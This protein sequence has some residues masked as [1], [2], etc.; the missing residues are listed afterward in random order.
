MLLAGW[1]VINKKTRNTFYR[2]RSLSNTTFS[3]LITWR[4]SSLKS[5]AVYKISW[6]LDDFS[7]RYGD[8]SIFKMAAVH[9]SLNCFTTIRDHPWSL[10]CWPQLPVKFQSDTQTWRYSYLNFSHIWLEM[11]IQAPKVGFWGL[12]TPK[13]DFSSLRPQKGTSLHK[14]AS[15]KLSAVKIRWGVWFV[16][17]GHA[18]T[19]T[20]THTGKFI[21]C[22]WIALDRQKYWLWYS[23]QV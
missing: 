1:A 10:C 23:F 12:W 5:A 9:Q 4:S 20:H 18:Q 8:I 3:F 16:G 13:C 14:S 6:K 15:F 17:D 2:T 7:L 22:P 19:H 21:F 11:P